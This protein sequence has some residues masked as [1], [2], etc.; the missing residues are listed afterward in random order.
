MLENVLSLWLKD[1]RSKH[2]QK[3]YSSVIPEFFEITLN[4]E[5]S[6]V[7]EDDLLSL[8]AILVQQH[9]FS[10]LKKKGLSDSSIINNISVISSF[11]T[12]MEIY[13][14]MPNLNYNFIQKK[15]LNSKRFKDDVTPTQAM[16]VE[17]Y[18]DMK[19]WL[20]QRFNGSRYAEKG[21]MYALLLEFM[22]NTASRISAVMNVTFNDFFYEKD[23]YNVAGWAVNVRDKGNK[24]NYKPIQDDTLVPRLAKTFWKGDDN[25]KVFGELSQRGFADLLKEYS[26]PYGG[27]LTPHSIKKGAVTTLYRI[28]NDINL[29]KEFADHEDISTTLRYIES[30]KGREAHGSYYLNLKETDLN[31]VKDFNGADIYELLLKR[32]NVDVLSKIALI[33][34]DYHN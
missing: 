3:R 10:Y 25:A 23:S 16:S 21:E 33:L 18:E 22:W 15:V 12:Q 13:Q 7:T 32:G 31:I 1:I 34:K 30:E 5:L 20:V 26:E 6:Q 19:V 27:N 2:T 14:V 4:K 8:D 24:V 11:F 28:T 29:C 17:D 9:Y